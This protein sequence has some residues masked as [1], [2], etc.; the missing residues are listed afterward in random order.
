VVGTL[1][2]NINERSVDFQDMALAL[3]VRVEDGDRHDAL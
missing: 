1:G 2:A 3:V